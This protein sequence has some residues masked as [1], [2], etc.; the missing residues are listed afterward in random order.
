MRAFVSVAELGVA[1]KPCP[2]CGATPEDTRKIGGADMPCL[3]LCP[4]GDVNDDG[5]PKR[6]AIACYMCDSDGPMG[7]TA[8]EA[9]QGWNRRANP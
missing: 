4:S 1:I 5:D 7:R 9:I 8:E 2:F 6:Y 3:Y